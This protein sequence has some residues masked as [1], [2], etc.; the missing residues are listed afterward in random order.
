MVGLFPSSLPVKISL[1]GSI[2]PLTVCIG[3]VLIGCFQ[4]SFSFE[5][6]PSKEAHHNADLPSL[7]P[8]FDAGRTL[9][10]RRLGSFS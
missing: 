1:L 9:H 7:G 6:S 10:R 8:V 5:A 3:G 4:E 2:V